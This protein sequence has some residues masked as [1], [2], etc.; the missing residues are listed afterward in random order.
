MNTKQISQLL[1]RY[2]MYKYEFQHLA[3]T[4]LMNKKIFLTNI[5][6]MNHQVKLKRTWAAELRLN[7]LNHPIYVNDAF[8]LKLIKFI[9]FY[10]SRGKLAFTPE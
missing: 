6:I 9:G 4:L 7:V 1:D 2:L 5:L 10:T 8:N 3:I